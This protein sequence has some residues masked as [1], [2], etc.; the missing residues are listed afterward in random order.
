MS[1]LESVKAVSITLHLKHNNTM[2]QPVT[3]EQLIDVANEFGTPVYV[4]H[5]EK[6]AQQYKS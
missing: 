3:R 6:I 4:Y 5:A 1:P 2:Y